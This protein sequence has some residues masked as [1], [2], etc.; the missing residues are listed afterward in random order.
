MFINGTVTLVPLASGGN[1]TER[2]FSR[3]EKEVVAMRL[4]KRGREEQLELESEVEV[5]E[6]AE[7][8]STGL[9]KRTKRRRSD[10]AGSSVS[11]KSIVKIRRNAAPGQLDAYSDDVA[12]DAYPDGVVINSPVG[13]ERGSVSDDEVEDI[14]DTSVKTSK[15]NL[16][17]NLEE[18]LEEGSSAGF[19]RAP[20]NHASSRTLSSKHKTPRQSVEYVLRPVSEHNPYSAKNQIAISSPNRSSSVTSKKSNVV[21][22]QTT[23]IDDMSSASSW[24]S[25]LLNT[26]GDGIDTMRLPRRSKKGDIT[27][28]FRKK[29]ASS[30]SS[31]SA[32]LPVMSSAAKPAEPG[33]EG[34]RTE[35]EDADDDSTELFP[36]PE[37][38][39]M[40]SSLHMNNILEMFKLPKPKASKQ[41]S[42]SEG[43]KETVKGKERMQNRSEGPSAKD[44]G[45]STG[46]GSGSSRSEGRRVMDC[47][48]ITRPRRE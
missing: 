48:L 23:T 22:H 47:V 28:A 35:S 21:K 26:E 41:K 11:P 19:S 33:A 18:S 39:D 15:E 40:A 44:D 7:Q 29:P 34:G 2:F 46:G 4:K 1:V 27:Y 30:S 16:E 5:E 32:L 17:E 20:A 6:E 43:R 38:F 24:K 36:L 8:E 12:E 14:L 37:G 31:R 25:M 3:F 10:A 13:K 45:S 9:S 42:S